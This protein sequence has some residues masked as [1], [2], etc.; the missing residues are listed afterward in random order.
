M[1]HPSQNAKG[2]IIAAPRSGSG[3]TTLTLGLLTAIRRRNIRIR[4]AKSGPDYID[5]AFHA[6]ATGKISYNLDSW[7]MPPALLD[8]LLYQT[9]QDTDIALIESS[10]GFFDGI[11]TEAGRRG[12]GADLAERYHLPVLLIMDI[13]GQAQSAAAIAHGFAT[14]SPDINIIGVILNNV[15]SPRHRASTEAAL[16]RINMPVLGAIP[17]D[18]TLSLPA[19]H[20]GL[21]QAE[22]HPDLKKQLEHLGD[23]IE[24]YV[25][26]DA[27]INKAQNIDIPNKKAYYALPPPGQYI[28]IA[29]DAAFSFIYPHILEGWKQQGASIEFFSPLANQPPPEYCDACWLPGGYPELYAGQLANADR[30]IKGIR[31]FSQN[32]PIHGECGGYMVMGE[33]LIDEHGETHKMTGLLSHSTSFAKRKMHLGYRR[34]LLPHSKSEHILHGHEFHYATLIERGN[35]IPYADLTDGTGTPIGPEGGRRGQI[36]GC[37]FH[38]IAFSS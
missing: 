6:A 10:M 9:M 35:D 5:P 17:R 15:A 3:K 25:D 34:A 32:R 29:R 30:F 38:S 16:K 21:I 20:L 14:F 12:C 37:F 36:T 31:D 13:S 19:R 27:V 23:Y 18:K 11:E 22:E 1:I 4:A 26:I 2:L 28:A 7:A 8:Y 33:R 24:K